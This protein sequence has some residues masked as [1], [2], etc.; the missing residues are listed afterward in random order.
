MSLK[1]QRTCQKLSM[2]SDVCSRLFKQRHI[3]GQSEVVKA[4]SLTG[5]GLVAI[6]GCKGK[7]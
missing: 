1:K 7:F 6:K 5:M 4:E 2:F 3:I